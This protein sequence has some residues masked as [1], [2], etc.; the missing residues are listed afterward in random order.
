MRVLII[1]PTHKEFDF[2]LQSCTALGFKAENSEVGKL[3]VV[4]FPDLGITPARGGTGK[5]QF[6][7]Q[8]QHL[9][10]TF[11]DWDLVICAGAGGG[12]VDELSIGDVVVATTTVEHDY[13]NKFSKLPVPGFE[14]AHSALTDL[15]RAALLARSFKVQFGAIASGDEDVVDTERRTALHQQTKA[16]AVAW[17]GAGG[18]R[19]C[20]FSNVPFLEIRGITDK[21]DHSAPSDYD[22]NL[23]AAINSVATFIATCLSQTGCNLQGLEFHQPANNG[24]QPT[25]EKRGG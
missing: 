15:R 18:A 7:V 17:E 16:L 21:A 19:A 5:V 23:E 24:V 22:V 14:G 6:A 10:D 9:L 11:V 4:R 1:T 8:A 13:H 2:F 20:L 25:A 3:P 12:L